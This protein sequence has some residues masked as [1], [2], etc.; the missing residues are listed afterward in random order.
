MEEEAAGNYWNSFSVVS[1]PSPLFP[2]TMHLSDPQSGGRTNGSLPSDPC[3]SALVCTPVSLP[4]TGKIC[5]NTQGI[6]NKSIK[7]ILNRNYYLDVEATE[8]PVEVL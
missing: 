1:F 2:Q 3:S 8:G 5:C 4:Q 7:P 6:F